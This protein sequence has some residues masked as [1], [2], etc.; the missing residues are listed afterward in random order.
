[1]FSGDPLTVFQGR[2]FGS[3]EKMNDFYMYYIRTVIGT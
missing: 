1:M 2:L 3:E